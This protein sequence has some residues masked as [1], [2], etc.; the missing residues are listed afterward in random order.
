MIHTPENIEAEYNKLVASQAHKALSRKVLTDHEK[1]IVRMATSKTKIWWL[2]YELMGEYAVSG[3]DLFIGYEA[4]A[5]LS[6]LARDSELME[7]RKVG[8]Y[9]AR[10][11]RFETQKTRDTLQALRVKLYGDSGKL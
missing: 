6:E 4:S 10:R 11:L 5:R 1:L 7:S 9:E 3:I 2:P 8:K